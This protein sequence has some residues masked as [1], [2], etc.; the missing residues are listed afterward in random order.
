MK[1]C[2]IYLDSKKFGAEDIR[3]S[4]SYY[5][6]GTIFLKKRCLSEGEAFFGKVIF[7]KK[8]IINFINFQVFF[9]F[10]N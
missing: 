1:K 5:H 4:F 8:K 9:A 7:Y 10:F 2:K 6:M 3:T